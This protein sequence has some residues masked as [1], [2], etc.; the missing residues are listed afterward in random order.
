MNAIRSY[1]TILI[2]LAVG[3][4]AGT[5][6]SHSGG[7]S[8][9]LCLPYDPDYKTYYTGSYGTFSYISGVEYESGSCGLF[10]SGAQDENAPCAVCLTSRSAQKT[11]P[12]KTSCPDGWTKEYD[13]ML[14]LH[15]QLYNF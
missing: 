10:P 6:F 9:Y 13:G 4:A 1:D 14:C 12:A 7:G 15:Y 11:I 5:F 8:E 2:L 3:F